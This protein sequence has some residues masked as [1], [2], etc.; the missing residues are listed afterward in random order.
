MEHPIVVDTRVGTGVV[1]GFAEV[2]VK[3]GAAVVGA[4]VGAVPKEMTL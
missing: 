3:L 4:Q 1:V 2:G